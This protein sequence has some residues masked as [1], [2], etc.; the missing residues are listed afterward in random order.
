MREYISADREGPNAIRL[1]RSA[2]S[3]TFLLVE[4]SSDKVF[5]QR[6]IDKQQCKIVVVS[7]KP[8][9]KYRVIKILEILDG[10]NFAGVLGI[11]DADCDRLNNIVHKSPNLLSTDT[12]DLETTLIKSQ[13]LDKV[14]FEFGSEAKIAKFG[15]DI[16]QTLTDAGIAV[17]YLRWISQ[18]D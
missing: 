5:Y 7:G 18:V 15:R 12:H 14:L 1:R 4:G 11:V 9:S 10:S 8:S 16:R 3:G 17:G 2:F 6:F 13:A